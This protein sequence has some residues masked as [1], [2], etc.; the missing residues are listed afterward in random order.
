MLIL[1]ENYGYLFFNNNKITQFFSIT[2]ICKH[3]DF[4]SFPRLCYMLLDTRFKIEDLS[5][6]LTVPK[7]MN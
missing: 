1:R 7:A 6:F 3:S 4:F 5:I 2:G